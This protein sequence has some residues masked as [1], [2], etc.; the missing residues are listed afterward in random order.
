MFRKFFTDKFQGTEEVAQ[1]KEDYAP[2]END[3]DKNV[4]IP[5]VQKKKEALHEE[6]D[7]LF[8]EMTPNYVAATRIGPTILANEDKNAS[9]RFDMEVDHSHAWDVEELT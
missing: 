3:K 9:N 7:D 4:E 2:L 8:K 1:S 5:V 6:D